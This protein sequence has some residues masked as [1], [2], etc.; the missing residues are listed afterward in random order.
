MSNDVKRPLPRTD[1]FDTRD[2]WAGTKDQEFR[3]QQCKNC[4]TV[5]FMHV[6]IARVALMAS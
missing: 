6:T 2:F 4:G 5:F 1:E 3:Y